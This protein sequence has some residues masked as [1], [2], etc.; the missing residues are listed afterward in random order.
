MANVSK[1]ILDT[2]MSHMEKLA[3]TKTI[4]GE[5]MKVG[6]KSVIPV[7]KV[8]IGFGAGGAEGETPGK[9]DKKSTAG[10]AGGGGGGLSISPAAFIVIDKDKI[11]IHGA[12]PKMFD[13]LIGQVPD[14]LEKIVDA[15]KKKREKQE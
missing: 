2:I 1:E 7:M 9:E 14:M 3:T 8:A 15:A 12:K 6:D 10:S 5:P 11:S 4:M 13:Q